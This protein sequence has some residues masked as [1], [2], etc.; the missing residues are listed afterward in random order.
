[1]NLPNSDNLIKAIDIWMIGCDT[2]VFLTIIEFTIARAVVFNHLQD[3]TGTTVTTTSRVSSL[4]ETIVYNGSKP[5]SG[6]F[7]LRGKSSGSH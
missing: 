5:T 3:D 7:S 6:T 2:F 1:M 4:N